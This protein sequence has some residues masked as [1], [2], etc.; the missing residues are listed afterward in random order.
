MCKSLPPL[1]FRT[2]PHHRITQVA[3]WS[4]LHGSWNSSTEL[5]VCLAAVCEKIR[6]GGREERKSNG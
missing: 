3:T 4:G 5:L 6:I 1:V 2:V